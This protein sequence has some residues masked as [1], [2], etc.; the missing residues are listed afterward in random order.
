MIMAFTIRF[1]RQ[2]RFCSHQSVGVMGDER[3]LWRKVV[4]FEKAV[5]GSVG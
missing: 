3:T 4:A 1:G 2:E 5:F